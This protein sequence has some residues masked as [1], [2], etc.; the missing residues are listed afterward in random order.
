M[1]NTL[2]I[3]VAATFTLAGC[4]GGSSGGNTRPDTPPARTVSDAHSTDPART[5]RTAARV[6][7]SLPR[8]GSVTQSSN[9]GVSG[10]ST[11]AA[12]TT[13]N[14]RDLTV[15]ISRQDG[16]R[17][18]LDSARHAV[19]EFTATGLSPIAGHSYKEW[20][21][22]DYTNTSLAL[23]A[24]GVS[25]SNTDPTDYLAGGY[26]MH[27]T[28]DLSSERITGM[29]IGAFIDGP[30]LNGTASVPVSG[31]ATYHGTA[32]GLGV[33]RMG[34]EGITAGIP[35]GT[36]LLGEYRGDLELTARFDTGQVEGTIDQMYVSGIAEAPNGD[37][38]AFEGANPTVIYL[39]PL[40]ID[41]D[42]TFRGAGVT[43]THPLYNIVE[44]EGTWG[45][46]FSTI[47]DRQG[48]PRIVAGT[49]GAATV[50]SG[51]TE[52]SFVGAFYGATDAYE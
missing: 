28:G 20:A 47:D 12:S 50:S 36:Y 35:Q 43:V 16:S 52:V 33:Q 10:I 9:R 18:R 7:D 51:G 22:L 37:T 46:R 21:M 15:T 39:H 31:T 45:G 25:W 48:N 24:A 29:E 44:S 40:D 6:A 19:P 26:W 2:A 38:E 42:G 13:F 4:G 23:S 49:H 17:L 3:L 30:E 11:D 5:T 32:A 1:R 41:G 34:T 27:A 8:F 14:G